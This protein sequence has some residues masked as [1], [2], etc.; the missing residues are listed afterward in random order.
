[1]T[2]TAIQERTPKP[3]D[4]PFPFPDDID[5]QWIPGNPELAAMI[6]G[7]S[8]TMPYLEPFLIRTMLEAARDIDDPK[9]RDD[10]RAFNAQ[11]GHHYK[12][13]RRFNELLKGK[14]Y[15]QLGAVE[16]AM[17]ASYKKLSKKSMRTRLAYTAGFEAM[18][19]G[20]TKWLIEERT[21]LFPKADSRV[22]SFALWHMVEETEH[23][24][25]AHD[26]F[27]ALYPGTLRNY[28]ARAYGV[29][30]GSLDVMF[31]SRRGYI[32]ML[33]HEGQW[34]T[35]KGRLRL[36][37]ELLGFIRHVGPYL[38]RAALPGHSPRAEKDPDW[39]LNWM[40]GYDQLPEGHVPLLDTDDP[41]MPVPFPYPTT[42]PATAS[43]Q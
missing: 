39:V 40:A 16:E 3:R 4:I 42:T 14:R 37:R 18:T 1:M 23:K 2:H 15:P 10:V 19:L 34:Q 29:F 9:V 32:V 43:A 35:L 31:F 17:E 28:F 8:L 11:E 38:L 5:P 7:A 22:V 25:V 13:H 41:H 30:H 33:K 26:A 6:N 24:C 20:V 12:T 27:A 36:Y 21:K